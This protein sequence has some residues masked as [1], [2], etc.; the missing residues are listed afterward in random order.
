[1]QNQ[2]HVRDATAG[3]PGGRTVIKVASFADLEPVTP[4]EKARA[5]AW[6]MPGDDLRTGVE[7]R[8][9][10]FVNVPNYSLPRPPWAG[11]EPP[12]KTAAELLKD[13]VCAKD[14]VFIGHPEKQR[15]YINDLKSWLITDFT[16]RIERA[17]RP[18]EFPPTVI[19]TQGRGEALVGGK[20][21]QTIVGPQLLEIGQSYV[22]FV[23]RYA[24]SDGYIGDAERLNLATGKVVSEDGREE[25]LLDSYVLSLTKAQD[26]CAKGVER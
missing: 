13:R 15:P 9:R 18:R 17:I 26:S 12:P 11:P 2:D 10:A 23:Q 7:V 6:S 1:M 3:K 8:Q 4:G 24:N 25:T 22:F 14:A 16:V 21:V 20:M 19:V 5:R